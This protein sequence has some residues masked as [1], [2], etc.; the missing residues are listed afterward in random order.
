MPTASKPS[1][2]QA[3]TR[4]PN[5]VQRL[6]ATVRHAEQLGF[7]VRKVLLEDQAADWCQIGTKKILFLD[8]A[9]TAGEQ[10]RQLDDILASFERY[11]GDRR[12]ATGC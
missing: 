9:A 1:S 5:V 3:S 7:E 6:Q 8:V 10:L 12:V 4:S 2:G 11:R